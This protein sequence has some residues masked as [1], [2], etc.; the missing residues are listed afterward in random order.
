MV[1]IP[2][3]VFIVFCVR[4][5]VVVIVSAAKRLIFFHHKNTFGIR[6]YETVRRIK[7]VLLKYTFL[8]DFAVDGH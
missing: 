4:F 8:W 6:K 2:H 7:I 3:I 1:S 5:V